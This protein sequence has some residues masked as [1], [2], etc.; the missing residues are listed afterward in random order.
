MNRAGSA[1]FSPDGSRIVTGSVAATVLL[2]DATPIVRFI[3]TF[4]RVAVALDDRGRAP[5]CACMRGF[6]TCP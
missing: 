3:R 1:P 6:L 4:R 5:L 2:W